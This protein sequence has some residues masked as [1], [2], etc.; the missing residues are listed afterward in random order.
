MTPLFPGLRVR[1]PNRPD[2]GYPDKG[3]A[4]AGVAFKLCEALVTAH[5]GSRDTL[6]WHLDLVALATIAD[7]APLRGENRIFAHF[8]LRVLRD[9]RLPGLR[10]L[11]RTAGIP[12]G[13]PITAGQVSHGL[14]PRLN[15]V[16][17]MGAASRGVRLL[18]SE[19]AAEADALAVEMD[20]ENRT[21]QNVD[22]Q[23]LDQALA[24]LGRYERVTVAPHDESSLIDLVEMAAQAVAM[25][26]LLEHRVGRSTG[27]VA[28]ETIPVDVEPCRTKELGCRE[29]LLQDAPQ[30]GPPE[31]SPENLGPQHRPEPG[32]ALDR[33]LP[34]ERQRTDEDQATDELGV[35][36]GQTDRHRRP[37]ALP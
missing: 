29:R 6:L 27:A 8:G 34:G 31:D 26:H 20:E 13:Q 12:D 37:E 21:R 32:G 23:I 19:D 36:G 14:A 35:H 22:R 3:L 18:L 10:A 33:Q 11:I 30:V 15:A 28:P 1:N 2:C 16:G 5:G 4:G 9:S 7:L 17:R 25:G 24:M